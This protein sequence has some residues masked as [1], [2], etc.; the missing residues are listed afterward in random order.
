MPDSVRAGRELR[1]SVDQLEAWFEARCDQPMTPAARLL[2][3]GADQ[4]ASVARRLTVVA[5]ASAG[6]ADGLLQWPQ[7]RHL[8]E[9]RLGPTALV[10]AEEKLPELRQSLRA[11]GMEITGPPE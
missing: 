1:I 4:P 3:T 9:E 6:L 11:L 10:V 5:V 8:I 7:T 2:L